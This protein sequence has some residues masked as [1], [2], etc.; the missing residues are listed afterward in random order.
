MKTKKL[1]REENKRLKELETIGISVDEVYGS[2]RTSFLLVCLSKALIIFMVC[3]GTV[4][5]FADAFSLNYNKPVLAAFTLVISVLIALLYL[6]K[7]IFYIGYA[8]LLVVFT[9]ELIRYYLYANSG[10][11]AIMNRVREVYAEHFGMNVVRTAEE[12]YTN[13]YVTI[14]IALIFITMF[15]IIMYNITVSRYMNFAETFMISF[16]ILEIPLYIGFKPPLFSVVMV[17]T[18]CVCTGILQRGSFNRITIPGK[19]DPDYI[20]DKFFKKRY[21]TTRGSHR[22]VI[23]ALIFSFVFSMMLCIFSLPV[24]DRPL[25]ETQANSAK[26]SFDDYVK[27]FVQNGIFGFF[28]KYDSLNGMNRG[29]LGGVSSV[30]PDF[31][32]DLVVNFVPDGIDTVY[33][34]GYYGSYYVG[35]KWIDAVPGSKTYANSTLDNFISANDIINMYGE[36]L[37]ISLKNK[38]PS[39]KMEINYVDMSYGMDVEPYIT[40]PQNSFDIVSSSISSDGNGSSVLRSIEKDYTPLT[41]AEFDQDISDKISKIEVVKSDGN[42]LSYNE[43]I[44]AVCTFIPSSLLKYLGSFYKEHYNLGLDLNL[45][46]NNRQKVISNE[47]INRLR[48]E[49]VDAVEKLFAEEYPYSLS[50]GKTP[51]NEDFVRYFLEYQKRGYCSHFASAG[52]M[53]LRYLGI[54]ARY[55]EGYCIPDTLIKEEGKTLE[56]ENGEEWYSGDNEFNPSKRVCSVEVSD[57]YAH[58]WVEIYLE[59]RGFVPV[60]LTPPSYEA[61]P[62]GGGALSGLGE[63]FS[64][65]MNVDLGFGG[66]EASAISIDGT[67]TLAVTDPSDF[68]FKIILLPISVLILTALAFLIMFVFIRFLILELRYKKYYKNENFRPLIY[69]RYNEYVKRMRKKKI[70]D[71]VNPLPME[72]CKEVAGYRAF[73]NNE[74]LSDEEK[75][76]LKQKLYYEYLPIFEYI[77]KVLYSDYK[78][79]AEEYDDFYMKLKNT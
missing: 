16:I 56:N 24:Y 27:I 15:L 29:M 32:T 14:T 74:N 8:V 9:V 12:R 79:N 77:E 45:Y 4:S 6:K 38:T 53:L 61:V 21:F 28:N 17:M 2:K 60:E 40:L 13:R 25:G 59:G 58:A 31:Q 66:D 70:I 19:G 48:L 78:S 3:F 37:D 71:A 33:L 5:G 43:Y 68:D 42:A 44:R 69:A 72:T 18:G 75:E 47:E 1:S 23:T 64:K 62:S 41:K 49:A 63:F 73:K 30:R 11:Q 55:V 52:V 50:P 57:Y 26:A 67:E 35:S 34:P 36:Y 51:D 7:K 22:G 20:P 46:R 54:P 39:A 65:L 10:F 76:K